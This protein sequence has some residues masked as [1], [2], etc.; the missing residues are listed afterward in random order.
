MLTHCDEWEMINIRL[1]FQY[2]FD[3]K[4]KESV[5]RID[6]KQISYFVILS[7]YRNEDEVIKWEKDGKDITKKVPKMYKNTYSALIYPENKNIQSTHF[8]IINH[9]NLEMERLKILS[10]GLDIKDVMRNYIEDHQ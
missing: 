9:F 3:A 1:I 5:N 8:E 2:I 4:Y 6:Y 10:V 7:N